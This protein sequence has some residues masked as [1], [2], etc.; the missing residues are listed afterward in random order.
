MAKDLPDLF[1]ANL[2]LCPP[3]LPGYSD[4]KAAI[5]KRL[6]IQTSRGPIVIQTL[7]ETPVT[8]YYLIKFAK[9]GLYTDKTFHRI[10]PGF[11]AQGG[12]P[13]GD[14]YGGPG[15]FIRDEV[16]PESHARGTVG[17]ATAGKDTGGS[18]FFFNLS[19][20]L[21]LNGRYTNFAKI[22][23][24]LDVADKLEPHDVIESISLQ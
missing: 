3:P 14:G 24:G 17:I 18:Q 22:V 6:K 19:D 16:S 1:L 11:V 10:V 8:A 9:A 20:N 13:R 7:D 2:Y 4:L 5:G 15:Y 21:H 23:S 12:D